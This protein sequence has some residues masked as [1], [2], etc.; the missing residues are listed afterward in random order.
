MRSCLTVCAVSHDNNADFVTVVSLPVHKFVHVG[1]GHG[2]VLCNLKVM[3]NCDV[4]LSLTGDVQAGGGC[5]FVPC[6]IKVMQNML[7]H[8]LCM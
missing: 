6:N 5:G 2:L 3:Q 4:P 1:D 7:C 8:C